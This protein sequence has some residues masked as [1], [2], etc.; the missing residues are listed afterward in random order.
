MIYS[1]G[2]VRKREW[3]ETKGQYNGSSVF[4]IADTDSFQWKCEKKRVKGDE[5]AWQ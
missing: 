4:V 1:N 3:K 5:R 2:S